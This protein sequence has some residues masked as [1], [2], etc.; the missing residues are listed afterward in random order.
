MHLIPFA[1]LQQIFQDIYTLPLSEGTLFNTINACYNKLDNF[2]GEVKKQ[3]V[4]S[5]LA[6]FD[7]TGIRALKTLYWLH[8]A[9]TNKLTRYDI[10]RKRGAEAMDEIGILPD[11]KGRAIH[12]HWK[13]YFSYNCAHG[14]C[15]AHHLRELTYQEEQ[16]EQK[17]CTEM[18][19]LLHLIRKEVETRKAEGH[20]RL[21]GERITYFDKEYDLIL[22]KGILE[23]PQL[24]KKAKQPPTI[25]IGGNNFIPIVPKGRGRTKQHP[26]KNLWD[27]LS[28]YKKETLVFM[29][30]FNVPFTNNQGERDI[31][32]TKVKQKISGCF[33]SLQGAKIFCR[34]RG[35]L[36]TARKHDRNALDALAQVFVGAPFMPSIANDAGDTS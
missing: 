24:Q 5:A 16:Y 10:D 6:H 32:M 15:N 4:S 25:S 31:R 18:K 33:R 27:R 21:E 9:A 17:W 29:H 14:L 7:E 8:V 13:A 35:Y 12:D 1:R 2:A 22:R 28:E 20:E 11:F 23:I 36:S 30:D 26:A 3:I 19:V 34:I